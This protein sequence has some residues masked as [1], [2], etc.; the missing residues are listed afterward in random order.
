M[1]K[2]TY[3]LRLVDQ[4]KPFSRKIRNAKTDEEAIDCAQKYIENFEPEKCVL[5]KTVTTE[6]LIELKK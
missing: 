6:L 3:T 5:E 1:K 4:G 2:V